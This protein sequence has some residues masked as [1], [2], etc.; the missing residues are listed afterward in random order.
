[1]DRT[2]LEALL[3]EGL[4]LAEIGRRLDR[5]ESTVSYWLRRYELQANG[6]TRHGA[7]GEL[8]RTEL[9][10]LVERGMSIAEI[11]AAVERSKATIRHW[12]RKH[13]L[14][15]HGANGR[16]LAER[17]QAA[18]EAG[19]VEA[20]M[21]CSKHGEAMFVLDRRGYYRCRRCRSASV[22]SR[23]RRLKE[24]L[25]AEAGGACGLCGYSRCMAALEFHHVAPE[26]KA[27]SLSEEGVTR[28]LARARAE[29]EKCVLL[30]AN[31]HAEV[32]VGLVAAPDLCPT[33][34]E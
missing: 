18:K 10:S 24:L 23:R 9:Q 16:R 13:G 31:C 4:S 25:V 12:L 3:G 7:R 15:T 17:N 6:R 32:E 34:L 1:M 27:F 19:R 21:F 11:A 2:V 28:S 33:R 8:A 14:R 5:H 26:Q 30:C 29:A 20:N 22:S